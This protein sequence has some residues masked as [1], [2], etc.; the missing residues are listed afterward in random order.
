MIESR[1][2][3]L[4]SQCAYK[5][6]TGC[7]GCLYISQPFWGERCPIKGCCE[8]KHL[9]NCGACPEFCCEALH[10]FSHDPEQGDQGQRIKQCREW[11]GGK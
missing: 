8:E 2:G 5:E 7:K 11:C 10:A 9:E 6:Q 1:C 4:C 3:L